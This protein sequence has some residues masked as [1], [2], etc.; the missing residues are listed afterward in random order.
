MIRVIIHLVN[1]PVDREG[2]GD[3]RCQ[4]EL[5]VTSGSGACMRSSRRTNTGSSI[6]RRWRPWLWA[7]DDQPNADQGAGPATPPT[8]VRHEIKAVDAREPVRDP[9]GAQTLD[10]R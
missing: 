8:P 2:G 10:A 6:A 7:T 1:E 9:N 3:Y 4:V 5:A